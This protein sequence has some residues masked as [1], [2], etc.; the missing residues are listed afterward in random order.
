MTTRCVF[1][2]RRVDAPRRS[3][4]VDGPCPSVG[5]VASRSVALALLRMVS[6]LA[7]EWDPTRDCARRPTQSPCG[8]RDARPRRKTKLARWLQLH[9]EPFGPLGSRGGEAFAHIT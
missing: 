4:V 1:P 7:L 6:S 3:P 9:L 8:R 5:L 2:G